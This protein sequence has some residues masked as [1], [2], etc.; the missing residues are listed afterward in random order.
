MILYAPK[1][2][3]VVNF[4]IPDNIKSIGCRVSGGADTAILFY[5]ICKYVKESGRDIK[6]YPIYKQCMDR[7]QTYDAMRIIQ[8]VK[9]LLDNPV[10]IQELVII[11]IP[12]KGSLEYVEYFNYRL[13]EMGLIDIQYSAQ[14]TNPKDDDFNFH[15]IPGRSAQLKRREIYDGFYPP[16]PKHAPRYYID[17][18]FSEVDK[19]F[20]AE[21]YDLFGVREELLHLTWSC[22]G[23][24][25]DTKG[26]TKPCKSCYWCEEKRWAFGES[27]RPR[28]SYCEILD[29]E[30][31]KYWDLFKEDTHYKYD[32]HFKNKHWWWKIVNRILKLQKR[33]SK[34]KS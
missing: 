33:H 27:D 14:T 29:D 22:E 26:F 19:K 1:S 18:P 6:V 2:D 10:C 13:F 25:L 15:D 5:I 16:L 21:M 12:N 7:P 9:D 30:L 17:F 11:T 20:I 31:P 23:S 3:Q 32:E 28:T 24:W 4:E 8:K 34:S